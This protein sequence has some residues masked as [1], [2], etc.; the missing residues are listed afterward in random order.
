MTPDPGPLLTH[1]YPV[2]GQAASGSN[3]DPRP[4][5]ARRSLAPGASPAKA[6]RCHLWGTARRAGASIPGHT[7][8]SAQPGLT[9]GL[10][11]VGKPQPVAW[12]RLVPSSPVEVTPLESAQMLPPDGTRVCEEAAQLTGAQTPAVT[13]PSRC[14]GREGRCPVLTR[15][16]QA[17]ARRRL[18]PGSLWLLFTHQAAVGVAWAGCHREEA[19]ACGVTGLPGQ[20]AH[21][22]GRS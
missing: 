15:Q 2:L 4:G 13:R 11:P 16:P 6:L 3:R 7:P 1:T 10:G 8:K 5:P 21:P 18:L 12:P 22:H 20:P 9:E 19:A 17:R 14:P